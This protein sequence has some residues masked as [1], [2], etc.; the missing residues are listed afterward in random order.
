MASLPLQSILLPLS[1][2]VT[3]QKNNFLTLAKKIMANF[4]SIQLVSIFTKAEILG[5]FL[6]PA[7]LQM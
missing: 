1:I 6:V 7:V 4:L 5:S 3:L 2:I